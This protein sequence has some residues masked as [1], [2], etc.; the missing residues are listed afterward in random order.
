MLQLRVRMRVVGLIVALLIL[1]LILELVMLRMVQ[2]VLVRR[3]RV[4]AVQ[5]LRLK[6]LRIRQR[7]SAPHAASGR[8]GRGRKRTPRRE[9]GRGGM[10]R[11]RRVMEG[12]GGGSRCVRLR[13]RLERVRYIAVGLRR[14]LSQALRRRAE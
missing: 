11:R 7:Q 13:V 6:L 4:T 3:R 5:V 1:V 9:L 8:H 10:R 14:V 12:G 2:R